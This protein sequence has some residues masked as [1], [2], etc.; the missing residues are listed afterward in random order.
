MLIFLNILTVSVWVKYLQ[1]CYQSNVLV[2]WNFKVN[3]DKETVGNISNHRI[4]II[5]V[6]AFTSHQ[7]LALS[8]NQTRILFKKRI[9]RKLFKAKSTS[10]YIWAC[11]CLSCSRESSTNKSS[12]LTRRRSFN[13]L[14]SLLKIIVLMEVINLAMSNREMSFNLQLYREFIKLHTRTRKQELDSRLNFLHFLNKIFQHLCIFETMKGVV[15]LC[16][17]WALYQRNFKNDI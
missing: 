4:Q 6:V 15:N 16:E 12:P 2:S 17:I 8:C 5:N 10:L 14:K 11:S 1:G 3:R 7:C 13:W 9:C